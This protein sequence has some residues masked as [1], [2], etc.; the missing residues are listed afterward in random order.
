MVHGMQP[1]EIEGVI[2]ENNPSHKMGQVLYL[3]RNMKM[4][5]E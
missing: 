1:K 3:I 4:F 5:K 2:M